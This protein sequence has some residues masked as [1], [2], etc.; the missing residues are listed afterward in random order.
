M[1]KKR[2]SVLALFF[3]LI[4]IVGISFLIETSYGMKAQAASLMEPTPIKEVFPDPSVAEQMRQMLNKNNVT[5]I[6]SQSELDTLT[7][8]NLTNS[9]VK[10]VEGLQYLNNVTY[11]NLSD[12]Q[13]SDINVLAGLKNVSY[14]S[15]F[16]NQIKDISALANWNNL[17]QLYV[18]GNQISDISIIAGLNNIYSLGIDFNRIS[19]ISALANMSRIQELIMSGNPISD[20]SAL[21]GMVNLKSLI[22]TDNQISDISVVAELKKLTYML[23]NNQKITKEPVSYQKNLITP[24]IIKDNTGALVSPET[25]SNNG[26]YTS[27][28]IIWDLPEYTHEVNYT[29]S[30]K[31]MVGSYPATFS[32]TVIQPL[33]N[34]PL[35]KYTAIFDVDG[36]QTTE[37]VEE[38][39]LVAEPA[40]PV[41]KGYTFTGWYD[42]KTDGIKWD[43]GAD[44][45]PANDLTP[46]CAV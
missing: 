9:G 4:T 15:L 1:R 10:S 6:V 23:A 18:G 13:I 31:V 3:T 11:L 37:S 30:Q 5:D 12:N 32:G 8:C 28:N 14:L 16:E 26:S 40:D 34:T 25:I 22:M 35:P 46:I 43:F 45:M 44:K 33:E 27:P 21:K 29:F 2:H 36:V 24:N 38:D 20:I 41:K 42:A 19:D 17:T 7:D 39:S